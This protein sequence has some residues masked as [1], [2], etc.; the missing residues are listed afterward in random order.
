MAGKTVRNPISLYKQ[1]LESF[2]QNLNLS[3]KK[4]CEIRA[5]GVLPAHV[6]ADIY[7]QVRMKNIE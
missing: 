2:V 7:E 3:V 6:L 5:L 4:L 1:S